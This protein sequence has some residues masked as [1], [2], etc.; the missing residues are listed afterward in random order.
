MSEK[1][2]RI[3]EAAIQLFVEKGFHASPMSELAKRARVAQGTLYVYFSS[4][5]AL[6]KELF[7]DIE[8]RIRAA[9]EVGYPK[10]SSLK[11]R[12]LHVWRNLLLYAI[13]NP[14]HFRYMEQYYNSPYGISLRRDRLV[15]QRG[16][17]ETFRDLFEEGIRQGILKDFPIA[18]IF[19]LTFGP[20][21]ALAR[22]HILG[23]IELK[24]E[25][26]MSV[27]EACWEG[28]KR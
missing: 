19:A 18:V 26:I 13:S 27:A 22:D 15:E 23:F 28:I 1:K 5:E 25:I 14:L 10:S 6:I 4:K 11:E 9:V 20:L 12:F 2:E 8:G 24:E 3:M 16:G 21:I 17:V 7:E